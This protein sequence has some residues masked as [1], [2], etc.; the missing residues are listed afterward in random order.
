MNYSDDAFATMLLTVPLSADRAEYARPLT[1]A[2]Y[3]RMHARVKASSAGRL[4]ALLHVD[5]SGLMMLLGLPEEEAY[6]VYTL[7]HRDVQLTYTLEGFFTKGV[8]VI[9]CFDG[10]YPAH[11]RTRM[12][13]SA[14]PALFFSG[15]RALLDRPCVAVMGI[16]GVKTTPEVRACIEGIVSGARDLGYC[17]VTGGELGVSRVAA[18][19]V[20]ELGGTLIDVPAGGLLAHIQEQPVQE[21]MP[22][23]RAAA[24]SL[25]HPEALFTVSHAIAR[26]KMIF[27]LSQA[28]FVFNT[29][30]KRGETDALKRGLCDWVYA[31]TGHSSNR[32]LIAR[33]AQ[34]FTRMDLDEFH[35]LSARWKTSFSEQMSLLD[36][37]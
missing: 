6:R 12:G 28:A 24:L 35:R 13:A 16:S 15:E 11:F 31:Y 23:G 26:N 4:G 9:T 5:I 2:E 32:P 8:R 20:A 30:G 34:P 7:F 21:M 27:S 33:G 19:L 25:E 36:M 37:L 14:P 29:D 22:D 18:G 3:H 10:D 1:T 17:V